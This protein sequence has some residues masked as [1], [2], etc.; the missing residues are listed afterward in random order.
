[1]NRLGISVIMRIRSWT[2]Q[3]RHEILLTKYII[4]VL[5]WLKIIKLYLKIFNNSHSPERQTPV[6]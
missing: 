5:M 1:M 2:E 6:Y 4:C 3:L